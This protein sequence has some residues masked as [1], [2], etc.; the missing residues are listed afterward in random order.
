[1]SDGVLIEAVRSRI[2]KAMGALFQACKR[3]HVRMCIPVQ[4]DDDDRLIHDGLR[5]G[6]EAIAELEESRL[7]EVFLRQH[8]AQLQVRPVITTTGSTSP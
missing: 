8:I 2:T 6:L 4:P 3:G 7:R 5:A 1:M